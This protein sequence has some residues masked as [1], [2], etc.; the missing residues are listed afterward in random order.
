MQMH[1]CIQIYLGQLCDKAVYLTQM[2][3]MNLSRENDFVRDSVTTLTNQLRQYE[4][5]SDIMMS[6]KKELSNLGLQL[7]QKDSTASGPKSKAQV[8]VV[9]FHLWL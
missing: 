3:K 2:I 1:L 8:R 6:I 9:T 5:H 7:L 4:N